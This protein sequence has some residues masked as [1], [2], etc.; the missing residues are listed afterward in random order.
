MNDEEILADVAKNPGKIIPTPFG[1]MRRL[2]PRT[3]PKT[4]TLSTLTQC[5]IR[6]GGPSVSHPKKHER[7]KSPRR[8]DLD[9]G[10]AFST[11]FAKPVA[12][13]GLWRETAVSAPHASHNGFFG[14][15]GGIHDA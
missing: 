7:H 12:L 13:G 9:S 2:L 10:N 8:T 5:S 15:G 4:P 11:E 14:K 6:P 3:S 1:P